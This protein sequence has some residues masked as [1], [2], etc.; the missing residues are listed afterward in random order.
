MPKS[1]VDYW[2]AKFFQNVERDRQRT[3]KL[4]ALGWD[5]GVIWECET[6]N[7]CELTHR[8]QFILGPP[9]SVAILDPMPPAMDAHREAH[10]DVTEV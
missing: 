6:R 4:R 5:V 2:Q 9:K 1:Q 7:R 3:A 8:L 10:G